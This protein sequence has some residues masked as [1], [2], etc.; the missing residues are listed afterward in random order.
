[1]DLVLDATPLIYLGKTGKIDLL[2]AFDVVV[3]EPVYQEVVSRGLEEGHPD[4][5]RVELGFDFGI[6]NRVSVGDLDTFVRL[7]N[8]PRL[9]VGDAAVLAVA[10]EHDRVAV[11]D[12]RY[13]RDVAGVEG[14]E[15]KGMAW[16][17][18]HALREGAMSKS[19]AREMIDDLVDAGWYCSTDVYA[20]I[21]RRIEE[22]GG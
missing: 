17:V 19:D 8:N 6:L 9:S 16:L 7:R 18:L 15:T 4:A 10:I 20:R 21:I 5:R 3:P 12:D 14:I 22:I 13:I 1:M 11:A 2:D